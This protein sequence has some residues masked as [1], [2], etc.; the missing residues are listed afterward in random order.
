MHSSVLLQSALAIH[1]HCQPHTADSLTQGTVPVAPPLQLLPFRHPAHR[2]P[3][4]PPTVCPSVHPSICLSIC[5][6]ICPCLTC[7]TPLALLSDPPGVSLTSRV[8][9]L[10]SVTLSG[11]GHHPLM[12]RHCVSSSPGPLRGH[13]RAVCGPFPVDTGAGNSRVLSARN[14][15]VRMA[16]PFFQGAHPGCIRSLGGLQAEV[17]IPSQ[18]L[19][20]A[21]GRGHSQCPRDTADVW[22]GA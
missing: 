22:R 15:S 8:G 19:H 6:S 1:G 9:L 16:F 20:E 21:G 5:P 14:P 18:S 17:E 11:G 13:G 4:R 3:L 2:C 12:A 10:S 7:T